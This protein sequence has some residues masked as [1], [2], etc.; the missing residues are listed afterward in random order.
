M[1]AY[2]LIKK[3]FSGGRPVLVLFILLLA[4]LYLMSKANHNSALFGEIYSVMLGINILAIILF[5]VLIGRS[6]ILLIQQYRKRVTGSRLTVKLVVMFIILS[7]TPVSVVYYFSVD[8]IKQGIDSWFDV[9]VES[10]LNDSLKLSQ[11][12]LGIR[13]NELLKY[14]DTIAKELSNLDNNVVGLRLNDL[15]FGS[16]AIELALFSLSG[17]IIAISSG[18]AGSLLPMN[19]ENRSRLVLSVSSSNVSLVPIK[20]RGLH[21]QVVVKVQPSQADSELRYLQA[22]YPVPEHVSELAESVEKAFGHYREIAYLRVPLKYSFIFTLSLVLLLSILVAIWAAFFIAKRMVAPISDLVEGTRAVAAGDYEKRLP[23]PSKDELGFLVQSFNDMT[24]R[25]SLARNDARASQKQLEAQ[26]AYL[27]AVLNNLTSGVITID[28][29]NCLYTFN[30]VAAQIL[31][32]NLEAYINK[33]LAHISE[34]YSNLKTFSDTVD[35]HLD[36]KEYEWNEEITLINPGGRQI[37][38]CRSTRLPE[39]TQNSGSTL[40]VF[41]DVT[42]QIQAQRNAAW[43][44]VARRLA[45]EIKNPLTPIQLSAERLRHKYLKTMA[46]KDAEVLDRSTRTIVQQVETLKEMVKAFSDYARTPTLQLEEINLN[47]LIEDVLELYQG[48]HYDIRFKLELDSATPLIEADKGR[49]HQVLH[50]LVKNA[51]EALIDHK[52]D[53]FISTRCAE[54]QSCHYVEMCIEDS[55]PG[56]PEELSSQLFDPYITSKPKGTGLGL[57]IVK[58]IIE[59]HGGII[60]AEN[61]VDKGNK[62][63]GARIVVRLPVVSL[64]AK[65]NLNKTLRKMQDVSF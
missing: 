52:G 12:S 62:N 64:R 54:E 60:L 43:G 2:T 32:A 24:H 53:I 58:K 47:K 28:N 27:D 8:F 18:E 34:Q 50:N 45:H 65:E 16:D 63:Q 29:E 35:G 26:H 7:A 23:L 55:G 22:L 31:Q 42:T 17:R 6:F 39:H 49:L 36:R 61:R 4:S 48:S 44:E 59:E 13:M 11:A 19:L 46:P 57:A 40:I 15:R 30:P 21:I 9:R 14:S 10:A 1:A 51:I 41:D 56:F 20:D 38:M 37:L 33:P 5:I 25:I 3:F